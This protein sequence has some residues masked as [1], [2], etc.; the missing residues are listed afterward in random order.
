VPLPG[1]FSGTDHDVTLLALGFARGEASALAVPY[2][3][4]RT[5]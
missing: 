4:R 2:A 5:A 1:S 3:R